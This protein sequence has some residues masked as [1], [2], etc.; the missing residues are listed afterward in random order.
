MRMARTS[1]TGTHRAKRASKA[2]PT[3]RWSWI[4]LAVIAVLIP[5]LG[6]A[7]DLTG[8]ISAV[9]HYLTVPPGARR[10]VNSQ[11]Q[12]V[13]TPDKNKE[14]KRWIFDVIT[15]VG[16]VTLPPGSLLVANKIIFDDTARLHSPD[17]TIVASVLDGGIIDASGLSPGDS[18]GTVFIAADLIRGTTTLANGR[19]GRR[20]TNGAAGVDGRKGKCDGFGGYRGADKGGNGS[21]GGAGGSGGDGG[22]IGVLTS[23]APS[24]P[25]SAEAGEG[26]QGGQGGPGGRGG[27]GCVGLGG[28]QPTQ[29]NGNGGTNGKAGESGK[30]GQVELKEIDFALV[31][32][33]ISSLGNLDE[34]SAAQIRDRLNA[35]IALN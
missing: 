12:F 25:P 29:P 17:L 21:P 33:A 3:P 22:R 2:G 20:G 23:S 5:V 16:D 11:K 19:D 7:A 15:V 31:A 14:G 24:P 35:E 27:A 4:K 30:R 26:G 28:S 34:V 18:G 32:T 1:R 6:L 8:I 13:L 9:T 10:I